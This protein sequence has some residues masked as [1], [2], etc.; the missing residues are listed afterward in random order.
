MKADYR[1][2][3]DVLKKTNLKEA[4]WEWID[5]PDEQN[6]A[7]EPI[8]SENA[9]VYARL[10]EFVTRVNE[11]VNERV[12]RLGERV[13]D[14]VIEGVTR[15]FIAKEINAID[16]IGWSYVFET[17]RDYNAF[18]DLLTNYFD[19]NAHHIRKDNAS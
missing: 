1:N 16:R 6:E 19:N 18:L 12:T 4:I 8:E 15:Q 14:R 5:H 9:R 7:S 13:T 10:I 11:H 2:L 17:E 3:P